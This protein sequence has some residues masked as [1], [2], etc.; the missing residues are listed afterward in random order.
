MS[1]S[2]GITPRSILRHRPI[3]SYAVSS[4][5][6]AWVRISQHLQR[7]KP[8][9]STLLHMIAPEGIPLH[10]PTPLATF[11]G[12]GMCLMFVLI[13]LGQATVG[14]IGVTL[15]D[16]HYGRPRTFQ[17]DAYVG[18]EQTGQ[19][20]HFVAFNNKGRIEIIELPGNDP[21]RSRIF[22]GPQLT[23]ANAN[24]VPVTLSFSDPQHTRYPDMLV[25]L[26]QTTLRFHNTH[27]TFQ[28]QP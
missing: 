19:P 10:S 16:I 13:L 4:D 6:P 23:G 12:A 24:L 22:L 1:S 20:S 15:D 25:Q 8:A 26:P 21:T 27:T 11:V 2:T 18:H 14:W 28:L 17:T 7:K 5:I 3:N 9:L